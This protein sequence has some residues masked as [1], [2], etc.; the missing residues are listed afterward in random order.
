MRIEILFILVFVMAGVS[1]SSVTCTII[2]EKVLVDVSLSDGASVIL[3]E[4][5]S[6]LERDGSDINFISKDWIREDKEWILVLPRIVDSAYDL[7][8]VLPSGYVLS[9]GLIY[10]RGYELMSDGKSIILRWNDISEEV[11]VFYESAG[12]SYYLFWVGIFCLIVVGFLFWEFEKR[13][14]SRE[15]ERLKREARDKGRVEKKVNVS[16]NLFGEEKRI[17]ELLMERKSCWMK[18]LVRELG[19]SKVMC[20]R[21]VRSLIEKGIVV[22]E[23][24]GREAKLSL[25]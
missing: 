3:P 14:F 6:L 12:E 19:I 7:K 17:V 4:E 2:D 18:E 9:D 25:S 11:I 1:A 20:T 21:K 16:R 24:F 5:Y 13:R 23:K 15:L 8:V 22:K 10:P